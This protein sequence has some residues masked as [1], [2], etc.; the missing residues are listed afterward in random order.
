MKYD[1]KANIEYVAGLTQKKIHYIGL[2][3][4]GVSLLATLSDPDDKVAKEIKPF[5]HRF[6]CL[7]PVVYTVKNIF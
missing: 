2:S 1:V 7:A 5:I 4:G 6:Y 3:Q